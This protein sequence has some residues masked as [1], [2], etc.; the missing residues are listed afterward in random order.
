MWV[1]RRGVRSRARLVRRCAPRRAGG[2]LHPDRQ[3]SL[4]AP[5]GE[6]G[7]HRGGAVR[8]VRR[9]AVVRRVGPSSLTVI[10]ATAVASCSDTVAPVSVVVMVSD[11]A[12]P[13]FVSNVAFRV[14]V[15]AAT[16]RTDDEEASRTLADAVLYHGLFLS[17]LDEPLRRRVADVLARAAVRL[18]QRL[19]DQPDADEWSL[20]FATCLSVLVM[21][22]DGLI[23]EVP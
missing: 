9:R 2:A 20:S 22:L 6:A 11:H 21:W 1:R 18:R 17:D 13:W 5:R 4:D 3:R 10:G 7:V 12:E 15:Q 8:G 14:L 16:E 19:L 23:D